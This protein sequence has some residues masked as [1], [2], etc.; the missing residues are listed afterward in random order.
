[1][2]HNLSCESQEVPFYKFLELLERSRGWTERD[3]LNR[4]NVPRTTYRSWRDG[5]SEPGRREYWV[6]LSRA[7]G[8]SVE[9]LIKMDASLINGRG[10]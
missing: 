7:F 4:L 6:K 9:G 3:V 5:T 1:M 10:L 2:L 8:V